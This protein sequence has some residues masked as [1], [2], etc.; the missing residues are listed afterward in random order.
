MMVPFAMAPKTT[1]PPPDFGQ[2]DPGLAVLRMAALI[3][4]SETEPDEEALDPPVRTT[5]VNQ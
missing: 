1:P 3:A 5:G 4:E 2:T